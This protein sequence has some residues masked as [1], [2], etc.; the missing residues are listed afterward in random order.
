MVFFCLPATAARV[1][2]IACPCRLLSLT[3]RTNN[4]SL[5]F[6]RIREHGIQTSL[7]Q[8]IREIRE[9]QVDHKV[10][11]FHFRSWKDT[12]LQSADGWRIKVL[13]LIQ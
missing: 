1:W 5:V 3:W 10:L 8:N 7:P 12:A 6:L 13:P 11:V 4:V 2:G 9:V